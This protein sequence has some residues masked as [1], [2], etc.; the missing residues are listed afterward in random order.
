[1]YEIID[2]SSNG[3][4]FNCITGVKD[5]ADIEWEQIQYSNIAHSFWFPEDE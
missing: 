4:D 5:R 1:M 2:N 3:A